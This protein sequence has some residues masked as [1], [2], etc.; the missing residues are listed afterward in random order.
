M[1]NHTTSIF[2]KVKPKRKAVTDRDILDHLEKAR[3]FQLGNGE[4]VVVFSTPYLVNG[5]KARMGVR[6]EVA[7]QVRA[8]RRTTKRATARQAFSER[9]R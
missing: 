5:S 6:E 4:F 9:S 3:Q 7:A 1:S 2:R 8:T